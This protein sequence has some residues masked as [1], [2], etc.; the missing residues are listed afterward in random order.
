MTVRVL[1]TAGHVDHGK[2][3]LVHALTGT[4][5]DRL[6]EEKRRGLTIELG[7]ARLT[8][9]TGDLID[10]VDVPGHV[11]FL[12][13]MLA[14][15]GSVDGC[16]LVVAATE[17]W[18]P[19][20]EEHLAIL[21]LLGV[22]RGL[23]VVTMADLVD[24]HRIAEVRHQ[25]AEHL[26]GTPMHAAGVVEVDAISGRGMEHLQAAIGLL[27]SEI[28]PA[29]VAGRPRLWIDRSFA[30]PGAGTVVTG[31]LTG[32]SLAVGDLLEAV[33]P[34][35]LVSTRVRG[36]Q[37]F[38]KAVPSLIPGRRAA[39]NLARVAHRDLQ[40]GDALVRPGQWHL[41]RRVDVSFT[42]LP[43]APRPI[44]TDTTQ[45]GYFGSGEYRV[46][47]HLLGGVRTLHPGETGM[48]RLRLASILP[49]L[50]GDRFVLRD[51]ARDATLGGGEILDVEPV[52]R[53]SR[54]RPERS[55]ARVVAERGWVDV[56]ELERLTGVRL[57]PVVGH[58]VVDPDALTS[59]QNALRS[60]V[61]A[62]DRQGVDLALLDE[63][64]RAMA[65]ID[66]SLDVAAGRVRIAGAHDAIV[67][68]PYLV[69]LAEA[70]FAPPTPDEAGVDQSVLRELTQRGLIVREGDLAFAPAAVDGAAARV[71]VLLAKSPQGVTVSQVRQALG[72]SRRYALA[73]LAL[74][75]RAG[76][77]RRRGDLR[78]AG[79]VLLLR[80][81][82]QQPGP[83]S[84]KLSANGRFDVGAEPGFR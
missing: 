68:H 75:D 71:A 49:L 18:K 3:T 8:L 10:L 24:Y 33:S 52:L 76:R 62:A 32:G 72:T 26:G 77:T 61:A 4:D 41:T 56:A 57:A 17:G 66:P 46:Q 84:H 50:P 60:W 7:F 31:T 15:V 53:P 55:V 30:M 42:S 44:R 29:P 63:R 73:L 82:D 22:A 64:E 5:P 21:G 74:L 23:V 79:P 69:L 25:I 20:T 11:R 1:A 81:G 45:M 59:A 27:V 28:S 54:A 36:L 12:K 9:P 65:A 78:I 43:S 47:V 39:V 40:R 16:L 34:S 58:W 80:S 38:G 70:P 14:G 48:V 35:G 37:S 19:Q 67:S 51:P 83:P 6:V 2:S 13:T